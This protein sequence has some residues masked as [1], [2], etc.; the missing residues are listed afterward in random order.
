MILA[1]I[2][3]LNKMYYIMWLVPDDIVHMLTIHINAKTVPLSG[4]F[5]YF[6]ASDHI[7]QQKLGSGLNKPAES[8]EAVGDGI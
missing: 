6:G 1:Y 8:A 2:I 3:Y 4:E 5:P 7:K